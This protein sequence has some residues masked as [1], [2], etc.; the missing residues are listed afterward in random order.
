MESSGHRKLLSH[1]YKTHVN[2]SIAINS[3][4][5]SFKDLQITVE[6]LTNKLDVVE[7]RITSIPSSANSEQTII[8]SIFDLLFGRKSIAL[9][10]MNGKYP[11]KKVN[12]LSI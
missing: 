11:Y 7:Q 10:D 1:T 5:I 12:N 6:N 8:T 9:W 3:V 2:I 4:F